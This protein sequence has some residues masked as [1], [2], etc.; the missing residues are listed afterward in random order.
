MPIKKGDFVELE[1]TGRLKDSGEV[2]DTTDES[3]AKESG[4][5][6]QGASYEPIIICVGEHHILPGI[7][8]FLIGKE[9]GEFELELPAEK[10][11]GK[12]KPQLL[13]M[14]PMN[15]FRDQKIRPVPGLRLNIDGAVGIVKTVSGGRVVIDFNHPLSGKDVVYKLKVNRLVTDKKAQVEAIL[16][17]LLGLRAPQ[18]DVEGDK[19]KISLPG[20][21]DQLLSELKKKIES[22]VKV[23]VEFSKPSADSKKTS[24]DKK[25]EDKSS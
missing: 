18:V 25:A 20:L 1:Y 9:P 10:A 24:D 23:E 21:P 19:V 8:E 12:K 16:R 14:I 22:L 11:F 5:Y 6:Q 17:V 4:I 7:D 15:M 13:Q 3:I 2:F